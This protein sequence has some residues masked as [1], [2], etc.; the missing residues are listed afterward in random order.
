MI[1]ILSVWYMRFGCSTGAI[2]HVAATIELTSYQPLKSA[3]MFSWESIIYFRRIEPP[4]SMRK[5]LRVNNNEGW[6]L[7]PVLPC[8]PGNRSSKLVY[9]AVRARAAIV[10]ECSIYMHVLFTHVFQ[11]VHIQLSTAI[12]CAV[13]TSHGQ[14]LQRRHLSC[15]RR[16]GPPWQSRYAYV[17]NTLCF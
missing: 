8:T 10:N 2:S 16:S 3:T 9:I 11:L 1:G 4:E 5:A 15:T 13:S 14:C 6:Y 17:K 12:Q 7:R